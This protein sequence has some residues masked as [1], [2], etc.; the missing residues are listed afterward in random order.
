MY[1]EQKLKFM[2][3]PHYRLKKYVVSNIHINYKSLFKMS[4]INPTVLR[5]SA[6]L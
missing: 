6:Y 3:L 5:M 4:S 1:G 2:T